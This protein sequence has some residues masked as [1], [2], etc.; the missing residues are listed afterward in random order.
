MAR[1]R[2]LV[3]AVVLLLGLALGMASPA[4]AQ[5]SHYTVQPGDTLYSIA[6][7]HGTTPEQVMALNGLTGPTIYVGQKLA[8]PG[9]AAPA[10]APSGGTHTVQP[11][12]T[13]YS[14][15]TR[16]GTTPDQLMALNGLTGPTIYVGQVLKVSGAAAP[17]PSAPPA[18]ASHV[19]AP[20][21]TLYSIATRHGM[22]VD[23][24]M[25]LNG[26]TSPHIYAGQV[27]KLAGAGSA[28]MPGGS[29]APATGHHIVAPGETL[30]SIATRYRTSVAALKQANGLMTDTIYLGQRLTIPSGSG[31][32]PAPAPQPPVYYFVQPGDTLTRIASVHG[33]SVGALAQL[34]GLRTGD[35]VFVGQR[36]LVPSGVYTPAP[37]PAAPPAVPG[38]GYYHIVR[39]G[40]TLTHIA[41][42]Y[43]TTVS[44]LVSAN[45]LPDAS[46]IFVG[47]RL[48]IPGYTPPPARPQ[49]APASGGAPYVPPS[50]SGSN[51]PPYVP[52]SP[53][54]EVA[55]T[56]VKVWRAAVAQSDCGSEDSH[57]F[58][59]VV[60]VNIEGRTGQSVD[61]FAQPMQDST[62]ITWAKTGSKAELGP[63]A[64][65]FAP[66][67]AGNYVV[68]APGLAA[69][70]FYLDGQCT[71]NVNIYQVT[72]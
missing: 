57:E 6:T 7:R 40:E 69:V 65:E 26:L 51:A 32:A 38:K 21:E 10:P 62:F 22:T 41:S 13:L 2:P 4:L 3:L 23:A 31:P 61:I 58:R 11:G 45:L 1:I 71:V 54:T 63:F 68:S 43:K 24:L 17:A 39:P 19:V 8:M 15:A 60:R 9:G 20:G 67:G 16:H 33:V 56:V 66:L 12:E 47:Q 70:G 34:N 52:S 28:P 49:P 44:A 59:S 18:S 29:P 30:F 27:L 46:H 36:L 50:S 5:G 42:H 37:P 35:W 14:I 55:P 48:H 25:A 53:T 72:R 64:A